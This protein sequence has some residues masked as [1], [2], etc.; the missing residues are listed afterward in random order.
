MPKR[1]ILFVFLLFIIFKSLIIFLVSFSLDSLKEGLDAFNILICDDYH[2]IIA[3]GRKD[4]A[5]AIRTLLA[6]QGFSAPFIN[7]FII[8]LI[9]IAQQPAGTKDFGDCPAPYRGLF[10][11]QGGVLNII[12]L[13]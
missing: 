2:Q 3:R 5:Q 8:L 6:F 4:R 12:L 10:A 13:K 9:L 7:I 1:S 11:L